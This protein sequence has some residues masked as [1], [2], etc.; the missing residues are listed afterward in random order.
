[1]AA[2]RWHALAANG[3]SLHS[4]SHSHSTLHEALPLAAFQLH[5]AVLVLLAAAAGAGVVATDLLAAVADRFGLLLLAAGVRLPLRC[6]PLRLSR[7]RGRDRR[8]V[9]G[10]RARPQR[11]LRLLV[12]HLLHAEDGLRRAVANAL[13]HLVELLHPFALVH[14]LRVF[15]GVT[16]EV[17]AA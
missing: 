17:G 15:L 7:L 4:H 16:G 14:D 13:P 3:F 12:A 1:L 2:L 10:P 9:R 8:R 6:G 5:V 11:R